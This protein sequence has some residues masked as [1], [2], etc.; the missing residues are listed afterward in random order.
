MNH[1]L[2]QMVTILRWTLGL[3][4]LY[5]SC[6]L[7]FEPGR[8]RAFEHAG[9]PHLVRPLLAWSEII[10]AALYLVPA[11]EVAGSYLL[12]IVFA[13]A[14]AVHILHG[15]YEVGGLVVYSMVVGVTL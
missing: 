14:A 6:L 7:A 13:L 2:K 3:V 10:A 8:I 11:S 5:E 4:V 1:R 12:L 9:F 15:Q